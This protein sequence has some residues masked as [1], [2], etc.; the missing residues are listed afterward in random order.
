[1]DKQQELRETQQAIKSG[2]RSW[3]RAVGRAERCSHPSAW[4]SGASL[5]AAGRRCHRSHHHQEVL[6]EHGS[7][8][9]GNN[10]FRIQLD[11]PVGRSVQLGVPQSGDALWQVFFSP[12]FGSRFLGLIHSY[13]RP[14]L[15]H[16]LVTSV[17][18]PLPTLAFCALG[19]PA[20]MVSHLGASGGLPMRWSQN[21]EFDRLLGS[22][23]RR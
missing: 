17:C 8:G 16:P 9:L 15:D 5:R 19:A 20:S 12:Y 18:Y 1:M 2:R 23:S 14:L 10:V 13:I 11:G 3:G 22:R 6:D 4:M 7:V 21:S